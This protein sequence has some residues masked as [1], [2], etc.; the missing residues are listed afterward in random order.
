[1]GIGLQDVLLFL[2]EGAALVGFVL[3]AGPLAFW[4]TVAPNGRYDRRQ[5]LLVDVGVYV[6]GVATVLLPVVLVV[7]GTSFE[8]IPRAT[9]ASVLV[10]LAVIAA[11]V[12]WFTELSAAPIT[13]GRRVWAALAVV[14]LSATFV[15]PPVDAAP[16]S[17][18]TAVALLA[19]VV[20]AA[21][22]LGGAVVLAAAGL[23]M[24]DINQL[25]AQVRSFSRTTFA[26]VVTVVVS[27]AVLVLGAGTDLSTLLTTT[28]GL[29]LA[30]KVLVF[31]AMVVVADHGRRHLDAVLLYRL[32]TGGDTLRGV[33]AWSLL[34]GSQLVGST[35]LVIGSVVLY[36][37]GAP[38]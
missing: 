13:G 2:T 24:R 19:H 5:L 4:V 17:P 29:V 8:A 7:T 34:M 25:S 37:V 22:W 23:P 10:R 18:L 30:A 26:C 20:A 27:S 14:T 36:T 1:M 28:Y 3:V 16:R 6:L 21:V 15:A 35:L 32:R 33:Q 9:W 11:L 38:D 31:L 12:S